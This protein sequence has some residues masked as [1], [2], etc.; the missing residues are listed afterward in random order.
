[1]GLA[2]TISMRCVVTLAACVAGLALAETTARVWAAPRSPRPV[3]SGDLL[4]ASC[5]SEL[6]FANA[7]G[8]VQTVGF[9]DSGGQV[10]REV[11]HTVNAQGWRGPEIAAAKPSGVVRIA[12][13]GDSLAFGHGVDERD[14]WSAQLEREFACERIE[15][16]NLGVGG[17]DIEQK[18]TVASK[19]ALELGSDIVL[20]QW[21]LNDDDFES[22]DLKPHAPRSWWVKQLQPGRWVWLDRAR[23]ELRC[24][25]LLAQQMQTAMNARSFASMYAPGLQP[26]H[27]ARGRVAAAF[28]RLAAIDRGGAAHVALVVFPLAFAER[29]QLL[30]HELDR[31]IAQLAEEQ[32]LAVLDLAPAFLEHDVDGLRIHPS[33]YHLNAAGY[34]IAARETARFLRERGWLAC[35]HPAGESPR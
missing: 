21:F 29:G 9:R 19:R 28:E 25:D 12:C 2:R 17:Y 22:E 20:V 14:T 30:S 11:V 33:D 5:D 8:R 34:A 4:G 23:E 26:G 7:P 13:V 27:P 18:A 35:P 15:A 1:M 31:Q 24:V 32:G 16:L 6:R 10:V 3:T